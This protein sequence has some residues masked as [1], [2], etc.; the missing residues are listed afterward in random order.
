MSSTSNRRP[1]AKSQKIE[2]KIET[3]K[4]N[5]K[6]NHFLGEISPNFID[7]IA[8]K[9]FLGHTWP[10]QPYD[11]NFFQFFGIFFSAPF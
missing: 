7:L 4:K 2:T 10:V 6:R 1:Q 9:H 8:E 11:C 5:R 3:G